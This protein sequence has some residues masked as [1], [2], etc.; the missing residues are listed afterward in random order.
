MRKSSVFRLIFLNL[1]ED[2]IKYIRLK[3]TDLISQSTRTIANFQDL[4][5]SMAIYQG[6][7][8]TFYV[9]RFLRKT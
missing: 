8:F 6:Q 2:S 5:K 4:R 7:H 9:L 3:N 1:P